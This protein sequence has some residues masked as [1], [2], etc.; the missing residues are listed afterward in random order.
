MINN[1]IKNKIK[2]LF[3]SNNFKFIGYGYKTING[4]KTDTKCIVFGVENKKPINEL[5]E[6][7]I[8]PL[9]V[10]IDN[11]VLVTDVVEIK[12]FT[13]L[14]DCYFCP[15]GWGSGPSPHCSHISPIKG[16]VS[17][18]RKSVVSPS[19]YYRG[20][21]G[22]VVIDNDT[23]KL[24][25]LTSGHVISKN[26]SV[27]SDRIGDP[28]TY[29]TQI[30]DI[31]QPSIVDDNL[32]NNP[33]IGLTKRYYPVS[34]IN[35]INNIDAGLITI[36]NI[37]PNAVS[38]LESFKQLGLENSTFL[39]F[40]SS[41]EID[42]L[43]DNAQLALIKS[44]ASSGYVSC[45]MVIYALGTV[46]I[47]AVPYPDCIIF[48][49]APV[50]EDDF[51]ANVIC[52][53]DSGSVL[54]ANF[55]GI[56]KI[57][58]LIF[59][60][61]D[62]SNN[63]LSPFN[64]GIACRIDRIAS[65]LNISAWNGSS[66]DPTSTS[67][68]TYTTVTGLSDQV[69]ITQDGK[70]YWQIGTTNTESGLSTLYVTYN[71]DIQTTTTVTPTT[72]TNGPTTT[73]TP[74]TTTPEPTYNGF[75]KTPEE[76]PCPVPTITNI[77]C[78]GKTPPNTVTIQL[79]VDFL[80][81]DGTIQ[82]EYLDKNNTITMAYHDIAVL[83]SNPQTIVLTLPV[84]VY[85]VN[86]RIKVKCPGCPDCE[87]CASKCD[88]YAYGDGKNWDP[89]GC[90]IIPKCVIIDEYR[91][92]FI[93]DDGKLPSPIPEFDQSLSLSRTLK[94]STES[95]CSGV[96][97]LPSELEFQYD[98]TSN[99]YNPIWT[100]VTK[101]NKNYDCSDLTQHFVCGDSTVV[102]GQ[103]FPKNTID[104]GDSSCKSSS[105][106]IDC[107]SCGDE[108]S[109]VSEELNVISCGECIEAHGF[110]CCL[111]ITIGQNEYGVTSY[112][113]NGSINIKDDKNN[114]LFTFPGNNSIKIAI[115]LRVRWRELYSDYTAITSFATPLE[116][117]VCE[118]NVCDTKPSCNYKFY[119]DT[120][121]DCDTI[122][123]IDYG[124]SSLLDPRCDLPSG[125]D[126][127]NIDCYG[128][129]PA[130]SGNPWREYQENL[131]MTISFSNTCRLPN[132]FECIVG[133]CRTE[134]SLD[135]LDKTPGPCDKC[136]CDGGG[137]PIDIDYHCVTKTIKPGKE[138]FPP[139]T[140][141]YTLWFAPVGLS[142]V[143]VINNVIYDTT[144]LDPS[145]EIVKIHVTD[146]PEKMREW[147][148]KYLRFVTIIDYSK[149]KSDT[150]NAISSNWPYND[151]YW[152]T[153]CIGY[154]YTDDV[155]INLIPC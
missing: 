27:A 88:D 147:V 78:L 117:S 139:N 64:F 133:P 80:V 60:G 95:I 105:P 91:S 92:P 94:L 21:M 36:D 17:I 87:D 30:E 49:Y 111:Y 113:L 84:S 25:G 129:N 143:P 31:I 137:R 50:G 40:A 69:N 145:I 1:S 77:E 108:L 83:V 66:V 61:A 125:Y 41:S 18:G 140:K 98:E 124:H 136:Y 57:V 146:T 154:P 34:K 58:G 11:T 126:I 142:A 28:E 6:S 85:S 16:G 107:V 100:L 89:S 144:K 106:T 81:S 54:V 148:C 8:I 67:A 71:N 155:P 104:C 12:N 86:F 130:H 37:D 23:N 47:D 128:N 93:V 68:W 44:S 118:D 38:I 153:M 46:E 65:I 33:I 141:T 43:S 4:K 20:T 10:T 149:L 99:P 15:E 45:D 76:C 14:S 39:P 132:D 90:L 51:P 82:A 103:C 5:A 110:D 152:E 75:D 53:G 101:I 70:K 96:Y 119:N 55:G 131:T 13:Y 79:Y 32:I 127:E 19:N 109:F 72:T 116:Y 29:N 56:L 52:L 2:E 22:C 114:I 102:T 73:G 115:P 42:S 122:P 97:T 134:V 26:I 62:L 123:D 74:T 63:N 48:Q 135:S 24:A 7:E 151:L 121:V 59:A 150:K 112:I 120:C 9:S 3:H 35:D 138:V